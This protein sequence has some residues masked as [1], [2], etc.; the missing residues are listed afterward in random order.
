ML[1]NVDT[2]TW[3][4]YIRANDAAALLWDETAGELN[5]Q[6]L[7]ALTGGVKTPNSDS[8]YNENQTNQTCWLKRGKI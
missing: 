5:A 4:D 1:S 2:F 6:H 7:E 3:G 8:N